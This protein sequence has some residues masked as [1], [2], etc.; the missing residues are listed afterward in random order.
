MIV[1][2]PDANASTYDIKIVYY[3]QGSNAL[4]V[5]TLGVWLSSGFE[6][7][8]GCSLEGQTFYRAPTISLDKGGCAVVWNFTSQPL[9]S[10]FPT[11]AT[12]SSSP[13]VKIFTFK[14]SGPQGQIPELVASWIDTTGVPGKNYTYSWDDSIRLYKIVS[15]AGGIQIDAYG[16]KTK[17]RRLKSAVSGDYFGT[18]NTLIGGN[19]SSG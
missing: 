13:L 16:A 6:Y 12:G 17:F 14:Y 5:K 7:N 4:N 19:Q 2:Y 18:G 15:R 1:G 8:G 10:S 9:L 11:P 3:W